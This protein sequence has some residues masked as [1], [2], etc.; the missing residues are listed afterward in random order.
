MITLSTSKVPL[1]LALALVALFMG[2]TVD[3]S[4]CVQKILPPN[5][6]LTDL[7]AVDKGWSSTFTP[8]ELTMAIFS[9]D[10]VFYGAGQYMGGLWIYRRANT[11][12]E[13]E[14]LQ[15]I[16]NGTILQR[17]VTAFGAGD[18]IVVGGRVNQVIPVN[19]YT[20][21]LYDED[22]GI[23]KLDQT[24]DVG[25]GYTAVSTST[26]PGTMCSTWLFGNFI[27]G[28][29][30]TVY[31]FA[32]DPDTKLWTKY[33]A[34]VNPAGAGDATLLMG[35]DPLCTHL[36]MRDATDPAK[37]R[38]FKHVVAQNNWIEFQSFPVPFSG[39]R[40]ISALAVGE[41]RLYLGQSLAYYNMTDEN[42]PTNPLNLTSVYQAG[43]V[44]EYLFNGTQY[45]LSEEQLFQKTP[46]ENAVCGSSISV[47][48]NTLVV[49]CPG[50]NTT[51][52]FEAQCNEHP[53]VCNTTTC[54]VSA[55]NWAAVQRNL[56]IQ[57]RVDQYSYNAATN[58]FDYLT[59]RDEVCNSS[60][61]WYCS[62]SIST[63]YYYGSSVATV[64]DEVYVVSPADWGV[65]QAYVY[66]NTVE[67]EKC[68]CKTDPPCENGGVCSPLPTA[69][70]FSC[71]CPKNFTGVHCGEPFVEP[72]VS[73][74]SVWTVYGPVVAIGSVA[75]VVMLVL[76]GVFGSSSGFSGGAGAAAGAGTAGKKK[77]GKPLLS[78]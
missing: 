12:S 19:N 59:T 5:N 50:Y 47:S 42:K 77:G 2:W 34:V 46:G 38:I 22:D 6:V 24:L 32:L 52:S 43:I 33:S 58:E 74:P 44:S 29:T 14:L 4:D 17:V 23:Y 53:A 35:I 40:K 25:L 45:V 49:G 76:V 39:D 56:Y 41:A 27:T 62:V 69:P 1:T 15:V 13:Y 78:K 75:V 65:G 54:A 16:G 31:S 10:V 7:E 3:A 66:D 26:M 73:Q 28:S 37:I 72:T 20:V 57:G 48:G 55:G 70:F 71:E 67:C 21:L 18:Y 64:N 36:I 11:T 63:K 9:P 68:P 60:L 61:P 8:N 30:D 51:F